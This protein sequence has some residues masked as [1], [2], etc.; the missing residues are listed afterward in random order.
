[1]SRPLQWAALRQESP[2]YSI[3]KNGVVPIKGIVPRRCNL[4]FVPSEV[5]DSYHI[6]HNLRGRQRVL[7]DPGP[8]VC[9][10]SCTSAEQSKGSKI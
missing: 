3:F 2:F 6:R 8:G 9:K 7:F 4:N 10:N 1:M 5:A